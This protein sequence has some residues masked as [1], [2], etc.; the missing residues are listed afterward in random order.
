MP[1]ERITNVMPTATMALMLVC[2][3]TLIRFEAGEKV[4]RQ[5]PERRA[6]QHGDR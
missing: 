4:R 6:Q 3:T 2:S 5:N 1:A